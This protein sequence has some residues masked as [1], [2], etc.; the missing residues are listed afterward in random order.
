MVGLVAPKNK[1]KKKK[2]KRKKASPSISDDKERL[3]PTAL[4]STKKR[5]FKLPL[6]PLCW[7][8]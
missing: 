1:G 6:L 5:E 2:K 7:Q 3:C 4:K 8:W